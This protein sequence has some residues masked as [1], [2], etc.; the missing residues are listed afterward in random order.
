MGVAIGHSASIV[1]FDWGAAHIS[2]SDIGCGLLIF[3]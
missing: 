3:K 1:D 2:V